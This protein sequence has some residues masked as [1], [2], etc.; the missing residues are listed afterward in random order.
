VHISFEGDLGALSVTSLPGVSAEETT[1]LRRNTLWPKKDFVILP[2][3]PD[4][5][6]GIINVIGG[7]VP[8]AILHIQ[9]EKAGRL[10]L[11]LCDSFDPRAMF[12]GPSLPA[13]FLFRFE[14]EAILKKWI[15]R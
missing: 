6:D 12:F 8:K 7:T 13:N 3:E 15:E 9:I 10:E 14:A 1:V 11:S 5:T 4:L 2:L